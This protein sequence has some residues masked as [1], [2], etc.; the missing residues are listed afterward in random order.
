ML[1]LLLALDVLRIIT[2]HTLSVCVCV[3]VCGQPR[4]QW[5][6]VEWLVDLQCQTTKSILAYLDIF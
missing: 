2:Y 6:R 1:L 5:K 3:C 4:R